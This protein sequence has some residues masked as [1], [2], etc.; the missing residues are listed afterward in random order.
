MNCP[1]CNEEAREIKDQYKG[2]T[3]IVMWWCD[4]CGCEVYP[5]DKKEN[6]E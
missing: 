3:Y 1:N 6:E 2:Q 5:E 4:E